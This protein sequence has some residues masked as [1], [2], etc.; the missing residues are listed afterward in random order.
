MDHEEAHP[1]GAKDAT[2][3]VLKDRRIQIEK[4]GAEIYP[5]VYSY[6]KNIGQRNEKSCFLEVG[7]YQ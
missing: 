7:L 2:P 5:A 6:D 1:N 3:L 4:R